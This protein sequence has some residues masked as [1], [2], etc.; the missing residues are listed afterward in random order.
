MRTLKLTFED[1]IEV[2]KA[3]SNKHRMA[4]LR[5]LSERPHNVN[6]LAE[7]LGLPFSTAAFNVNKLE[8]VNLIS[9]ELVPGRGTQ[10]INTRNY[11]QIII[12]ISPQEENEEEN[13]VIYDMPIGE[14]FDCFIEPSCGL[15]S[16]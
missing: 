2:S 11:D 7:R 4:I 9:T 3:V 12:D 13:T 10:K 8:E 16:V 15:V 5:L 1:A 14:Y 6:E